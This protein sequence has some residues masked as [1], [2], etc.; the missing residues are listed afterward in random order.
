M[1]EDP[2]ATGND[3]DQLRHDI[4]ETRENMEKTLDEI[5]Q[6]VSPR[7]RAQRSRA[8]LQQRIGDLK[9]SATQRLGDRR[10][11]APKQSSDVQARVPLIPVAGGLAST[12]VSS[13]VAVMLRQRRNRIREEQAR[14]R[15]AQGA[16]GIATLVA[17]GVL[18]AVGKALA[19]RR[20]KPAGALTA[21]DIMTGGAECVMETDTLVEAA[22]KM[23]RLDVG[24]LPICGADNRLKGM[25]TDRDIV[26]KAVAGE[27]NLGFVTAGEL[28][29]GKPVTIGADDSVA[30]AL[31]TMS[32]HKVR[33]LP[34]IDGHT[35][36]GV[37]SQADIAVRIDD[38]QTGAL[39]EAI[40]A[41]P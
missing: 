6:R 8:Q 2:A 23:V 25:L 5:G 39:V 4:A 24:A 15:S 17:A 14:R 33:R 20:S 36:I 34:V 3:A 37:V 28:A 1:A 11:K 26:V 27:R 10:T 16:T 32:R 40:S 30:E 21:R 35:L 9:N 41:A 31:R 22:R 29:Q 7:V 38:S 19:S 13:A 12:G 18:G